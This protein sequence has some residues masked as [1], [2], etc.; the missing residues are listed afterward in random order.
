MNKQN[1]Y[2]IAPYMHCSP[3]SPYEFQGFPPSFFERKDGSIQ[4]TRFIESSRMGLVMTATNSIIVEKT[5]V[6]IFKDNIPD[7]FE[8]TPTMIFRK[9]TAEQWDNY[10]KITVKQTVE[11]EDYIELDTTGLQLWVIGYDLYV[12]PAL[13]QVLIEQGIDERLFC[14]GL[15]LCAC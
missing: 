6:D 11:R 4:I 15:P 13:C 3:D 9:K 12:S 10:Y 5:L 7:Q 8:I 14:Q 1:P 2:R